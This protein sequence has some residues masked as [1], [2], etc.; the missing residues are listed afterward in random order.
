MENINEPYNNRVVDNKNKYRIILAIL[1]LVIVGLGISLFVNFRQSK[2]NEF[3]RS[4]LDQT[5]SEMQVIKTELEAKIVEIERLGGDVEELKTVREEMDS[6]MAE[7]KKQNQMAW[8]SYR[9]IQN[10]VEGYRELLLQKDEEIAK[11]QFIN[12]EL[13]SENI[14]LKDE[15]NQLTE[16]ISM[17]AKAATKLEEKVGLAS[18]LKA[19]N[20]SVYAINR[21]GRERTGDIRSRQIEQ[22]KIDFSISENNVAPFGGKDILI[23]IIEPEG[24]VLFDV[25]R[26]SGTF[27]YN[28]REEFFT[29]KQNILFDNSRQQLSFIYEKG[30][31]FI[32]GRH[33]VEIYTDGYIM[34]SESFVVK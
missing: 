33:T 23:R 3:V 30:T 14:N 18:R 13:L 25:A 8:S 29:A 12:E 16:S 26:G 10:R 28:G 2:S 4:E 17:M 7:L 22:L 11:L 31:D 6:E 15:K 21:R 5:Y 32:E 24:N 1:A 34:G 19:E 20:I 9:N 27:M